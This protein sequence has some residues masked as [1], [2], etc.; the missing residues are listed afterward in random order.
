MQRRIFFHAKP[1]AAFVSL[2]QDFKK[3]ARGALERYGEEGKIVRQTT[4]EDRA[5]A[6]IAERRERLINFL[7]MTQRVSVCKT[8][9]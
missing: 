4:C 7:N 8:H 6:K 9:A 5:R 3:A 1:P 2:K